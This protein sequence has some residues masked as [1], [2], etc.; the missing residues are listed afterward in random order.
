MTSKFWWMP[1]PGV[2]Q[3]ALQDASTLL[4]PHACHQAEFHDEIKAS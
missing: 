4:V 2:W 3:L 1:Y